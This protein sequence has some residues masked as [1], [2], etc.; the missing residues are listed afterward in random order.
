MARY[1]RAMVVLVT[2]FVA[3]SMAGLTLAIAGVAGPLQVGVVGLALWAALLVLWGRAPVSGPARPDPRTWVL[4]AGLLVIAVSGAAN[5]RHQGLYVLTNRDPGIYVAGGRW[6]AE[7]GN[8]VVDGGVEAVPGLD[9]LDGLVAAGAGQ[10]E[11]DGDPNRIQIQGAH[12][13]PTVLAVGEWVAG[14]V[15]FGAAPAVVGALALAAFFWLALKLLPDWA[16]LAA[17]VAL[18]VD[19][20]WIY[21]VRS[22][23]SEPTLLL[24]SFAAAALLLDAVASWPTRPTRLAVAGFV[25]ATAL[26]ARVDAGVVILTFP[27]LVAVLVR[28]QGAGARTGRALGWWCLGAAGPAVV[29]AVDLSLRSPRY[30]SDLGSEA[31]LVVVGLAASLVVAVGVAATTQGRG[32]VA[33][34]GL[35]ERLR[36]HLPRLAAAAA[37]LVVV[38]AAFAWFVRPLLGPDRVVRDGRPTMESIQVHEGLSPDGNRTYAERSLDRIRWY[39]GPVAVAAGAVG[40]AVLGRRLV[41]GRL[42]PAEWVV[43]G[44]VTPGLVLYAY[45]PSIYSDHPWMI[46][47]YVPTAIP[48]LLLFSGVTA[49]A[50][51]G[52]RGPTR[53]A[54][55]VG[56]VLAALVVAGLVVG[57]LRMSWPLRAATW[58]A[59]GR[60]GIERVCGEIGPDDVA[61]LTNQGD[62]GGQLLPAIHAFCGVDAVGLDPARPDPGDGAVTAA[63]VAGLVGAEGRRLQVI[64]PSREAVLLVS[65]GAED[66]RPVKVLQTSAVGTTIGRPP[67]AVGDLSFT[68]WVGTVEPPVA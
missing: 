51:A 13:F 3:V 37:A 14:D 23:L 2:G 62:V 58:Y 16:A 34:D 53:R 57:P 35:A 11:T 22:Y 68:V 61:L 26:T 50:L 39:T 20:A 31:T 36:P 18:A 45:A 25:A 30:L 27:V 32:R 33:V 54:R 9:S 1:V 48:G 65:P 19:F 63:E 17:T 7:H 10:T 55:R 46:R 12:L 66:L 44:L 21:T 41:G 47:R 4:V 28:R 24:V 29:A 5:V 52:W 40:L 43:A 56:P 42:S 67:S 49:A 8:L 6:M 15:G 38:V 64:G 59:D 60:T